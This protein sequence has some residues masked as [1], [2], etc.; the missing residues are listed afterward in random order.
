MRTIVLINEKAGSVV[1]RGPETLAREIRVAF[2]EAGHAVEVD[3]CAP[4]RMT[5][6]IETA[7]A[8]PDVDAIVAGGGDGTL[9]AAAATLAGGE[10]ALGCLPLGTMN[11]YCR[12]LGMPMDVRAAVRALAQGRIGMA[13]MG[14]VNGRPFLHHVS[15][16]LQPSIVMTRNREDFSGRL[17]K[18]W[19]TAKTFFRKLRTASPFSV[20]ID[21]P[22]GVRPFR[23]PAIFVTSNP[24][25][26]DRTGIQQARN[27][28]RLGLY[29]CTSA[30][31][32]DL[33]RVGA[34]MVLSDGEGATFL[35]IHELPEVT[36][37][38]RRGKGFNASVDGEI[39][40]FASPLEIACRADA[41]RLLI[42]ADAPPA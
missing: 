20:A 36:I 13:D 26:R 12:A 37:R 18:M 10:V 28:H 21:F 8:R 3:C 42:P 39:V 30:R 25:L 27:A 23:V 29:I 6:A 1:A 40:R 4:K 34:S 5:A 7:A 17:G 32:D 19:A 14:L 15:L 9:S 35:E 16:G 11:L 38:R 2:E 33:L 31:W 24:L 22:D 41:L